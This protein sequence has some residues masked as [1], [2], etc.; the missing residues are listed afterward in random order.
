MDWAASVPQ[1]VW[2]A[3][4]FLYGAIVGSFLNVCIYRIPKGIEVVR[5][6]SHCP[7]CGQRI[8]WFRNIPILSWLILRGRAACCG[9][10]ISFR[11]LL[12]ELAGASIT[13]YLF[14]TLGLSLELLA[15]WIFSS[16]LLVLAATDWET[17]RLPNI[18]TLPGIILGLAFAFAG[19]RL[20]LVDAALGVLAG[21]GGF[22]AIALF[23]RLVRKQEGMGMGDVKLMGMIGAFLGWL[24]TLLVAFLGSL[25]AL[26]FSIFIIARSSS[27]GKT[28]L[29]HGTFICVAALIALLWG[30]EII[31]W[32][33]GL[34]FG[35]SIP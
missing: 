4:A 25:L 18:L 31:A 5:T 23:Y 28:K 26:A 14:A 20:G 9:A 2:V 24:K 33:V 35:P 34:V 13:A 11:Y 15:A 7:S 29:R 27:G 1:Q 6:P 10:R 17:W 3:L 16:F 21:G 30:D 19:V 22:L 12:I 8:P 32:Y